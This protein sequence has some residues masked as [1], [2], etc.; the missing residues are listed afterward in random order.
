MKTDC[1]GQHQ[2]CK[3]NVLRREETMKLCKEIDHLNSVMKPLVQR[4]KDR[5]RRIGLARKELSCV[6]GL[7]ATEFG[8]LAGILDLRRPLRPAR[9]GRR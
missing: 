6:R 2:C 9:R 1:G 7:P 4:L 5:E 8:P 3:E